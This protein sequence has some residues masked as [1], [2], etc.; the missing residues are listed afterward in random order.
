[1]EEW[2][3]GTDE[4][5]PR[6]QL[7]PP[8]PITS[9]ALLSPYA[10]ISRRGPNVHGQPSRESLQ[11]STSS[12]GQYHHRSPILPP[13]STA[14]SGP[15]G[16]ASARHLSPNH[17]HNIPVMNDD[18]DEDDDDESGPVG[19]VHPLP[20]SMQ[21]VQSHP[22]PG[23]VVTGIMPLPLGAGPRATAYS[24]SSSTDNYSRSH[25][26]TPPPAMRTAPLMGPDSMEP[27]R[28]MGGILGSPN[29]G[30]YASA[31][32]AYAAPPPL[33][34]VNIPMGAP[35]RPLSRQV[36]PNPNPAGAWGAAPP[37]TVEHARPLSRQGQPGPGA[38][39]PAGGWGGAPPLTTEP[40]RPL[41]RQ[42]NPSGGRQGP[43]GPSWGAP[44]ALTTEPSRPPSR[45]M[46]GILG[47]PATATWTAPPVMGANAPQQ[48]GPQGQLG[49]A[50]PPGGWSF[51]GPYPF[52]QTR[53]R[54]L[55]RLPWDSCPTQ[56]TLLIRHSLF[57]R[58]PSQATRP[59]RPPIYGPPTFAAGGYPTYTPGGAAGYPLPA[60]V[61]N[62]SPATTITTAHQRANAGTTPAF[63]PRALTG[64][65]PGSRASSGRYSNNQ[66]PNPNANLGITN[67][68]T[69]IA[70]EEGEGGG[71]G[72]SGSSSSSERL[73]SR[74]NSMDQMTAANTA[75]NASA[76]YLGG[77][78]YAGPAIYS[79]APGIYAAAPVIPVIPPSPAHSYRP[80]R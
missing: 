50:P 9:P 59:P 37:L 28:Q 39:N 79:G 65:R 45:Q 61:S 69:S 75:A 8:S 20:A 1:M 67:P 74:M 51:Q 32:P 27:A 62:S 29:A 47:N 18:Y 15:E 24:S 68:Y 5:A 54:R 25:R 34:G 31:G 35:P 70:E 43:G 19:P 22:P 13:Q 3:R 72:S 38:G 36:N 2:R 53:R 42:G 11:S 44:P 57:A 12:T 56:A 21:G 46:G 77:P 6:N 73:P 64:S 26:T 55:R 10:P 66:T 33:M 71:S 40:V 52:G 78:V 76:G 48:H 16:P 60:S 49:G 4:E 7:P 80:V 58:C 30:G 14:Y 63:A 17:A 23:F 41:S